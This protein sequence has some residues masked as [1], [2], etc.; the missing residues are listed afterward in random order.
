V[1]AASAANGS[2]AAGSTTVDVPMDRNTSQRRAAVCASS[3]AFCGSASPNHTTP[4]RTGAPQRAH[5]GGVPGS[6]SAAVS[7]RPSAKHRSSMMLP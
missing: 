5:R 6:S 1:P 4:G 7:T 2:D 3:S